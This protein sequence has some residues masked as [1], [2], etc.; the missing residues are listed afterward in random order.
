[1]RE[2]RGGREAQREPGGFAPHAPGAPQRACSRDEV[3]EEAHD[4]RLRQELQR[5]VVRLVDDNRSAA[6]QVVRE[7]ERPGPGS[8]DGMPGERVPGLLPPDPAIPGRRLQARRRIDD[9]R[10]A[11]VRE[12]VPDPARECDAE[13]DARE[14]EQEC[15]E[16]GE[17]LDARTACCGD[18]MARDE[19]RSDVD[20]CRAGDQDERE[21]PAVVHPHRPRLLV[22]R[23]AGQR[24]RDPERRRADGPAEPERRETLETRASLDENPHD[25]C[26]AR[27]HDAE[28]RVGEQ[29]RDDECVEQ[30]DALA[31]RR[32]IASQSAIGTP[33]SQSS[34]SSF[35]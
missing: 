24:E 18:R 9:L 27:K 14:R 3:E 6:K 13:D 16:T 33:T 5:N 30:D 11:G 31:L 10:V 8:A 21:D 19:A 25:R 4:P 26:G 32:A 17:S 28:A 20:D 34:A 1:M 15:G 7:L 23:D 35:Q 2:E 12:L 29:E 22:L